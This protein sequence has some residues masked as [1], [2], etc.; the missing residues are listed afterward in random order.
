MLKIVRTIALPLL[1]ATSSLA[2]SAQDGVVY[3]EAGTDPQDESPYGEQAIPPNQQ[4]P[5][6]NTAGPWPPLAPANTYEDVQ[7]YSRQAQP[8]PPA[9]PGAP[10]GDLTDDFPPLDINF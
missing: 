2:A 1:L 9:Q 6:E 4:N 10:A 5:A 8:T 7:H 3:P